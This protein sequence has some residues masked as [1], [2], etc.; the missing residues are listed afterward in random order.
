MTNP[1]ARKQQKGDVLVAYCTDIAWSPFF[2]LL[3][4]VV[5]ELGGLISHG[6]VV[7][8]EYGIPCIVG[9]AGATSAIRTGSMV[10]LDGS[11]G[12][13]QEVGI[14]NTHAAKGPGIL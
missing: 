6:A 5:T 8:R 1:E 7:A 4:G 2:P 11:I 14:H 13:L 12:T 9:A 3:S 10:R